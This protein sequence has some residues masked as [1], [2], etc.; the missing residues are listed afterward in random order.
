MS[1]NLSANGLNLIKSFEGCKLTAYKCFPTEKYYTIGYGHYGSDVKAGMKITAEQAEELLLQDCGKA[2]KNVNSFMGTYNFNQNQFDA[3]TSFAFN[4][5]SIDGL[6]NHG[7]RS[8][9][10]ISN[11]ITLYNKCGGVVLKGLVKRRKAEKE[12]FDKNSKTIED[13]AK[14]VIKGKYGNGLERIN[15]ITKLGY[16]Y[17]EVQNVVNKL[18]KR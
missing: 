9:K 3:L 12:L 4:I 11:K 14:E 1:R 2:I 13:V 17:N 18:I 15:N 10:E 6:T 5:G 8:I 16:N 7:K